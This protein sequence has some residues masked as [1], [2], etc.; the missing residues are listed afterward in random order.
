[1]LYLT[2]FILNVNIVVSHRLQHLDILLVV[3]NPCLLLEMDG[4]G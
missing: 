2:D 4:A 3:H 1:M